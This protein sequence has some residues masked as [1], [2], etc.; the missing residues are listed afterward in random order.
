MAKAPFGNDPAK[1]ARYR[2]FWERDDV[3]R[4][5]TGFT[6]VG[7]F[8]LGE[9]AA[10]KSWASTGYLKPEMVAP[11]D[12]AGDHLRMLREGESLDDDLIRGACPAQAA[13]PW[14]P[15]SLGSRLRILPENVLGEEQF[16]T[17]D[18]AMNVRLDPEHPLLR[19]YIGFA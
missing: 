2:A 4:P 12:F 7:W 16:L 18:Q 3:S 17:W 8:P 10:C 13:V 11:E 9:F 1:I 15:A 19:K 6:F 5:L 14:L